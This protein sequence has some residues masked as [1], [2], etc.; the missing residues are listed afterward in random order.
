[1]IK[2]KDIV[3]IGMQAWDIEIGSNC[4]ILQRNS[5]SIIG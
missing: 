1:M 4:K 2:G 5:Q 3:I